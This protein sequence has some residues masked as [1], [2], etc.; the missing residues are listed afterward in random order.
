M[1]CKKIACLI[2]VLMMLLSFGIPASAQPTDQTQPTE[3]KLPA[4]QTQPAEQTKPT[5]QAQPALQTTAESAVLMEVATGKILFEKNPDKELPPASVTK[6]MTL[7]VALEAVEKGKVKLTD[8]VTASENASKMGGSQIYLEE[9][10]EFDLKTMLISVAV[11][12]ANDACVAV[13]EHIA[14]SH[15]AYVKMMN[16]KAAELGLKHTKFVN[17]YGLP[18]NGHY[19]SARDLALMM[20]EAIKYPLFNELTTI[21][22]HDL[23]GGKFVLLNTNKLLWWYKGAAG[24]K[25]GWTSEA[26][27]CLASTAN[28]DN[29]RLITVVMASPEPR[30]HFRESMKIFNYGFAQYEAVPIAKQG[31]ELGQVRVLKG[32][33]DDLRLAAKVDVGTVVKKGHKKDVTHKI[34]MLPAI[35]APVAE[36]QVIGDIK[37]YEGKEEVLKVDLVATKAIPKGMPFRQMVKLMRAVYN[38]Q[39]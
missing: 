5:E 14:G 31:Q 11:G 6:V 4:Q 9:G 17:A 3:Q 37:V 35:T 27:Y 10:E 19:T 12:S 2:V 26:K 7:L 30:S 23:R 32:T 24:G 18:A 13:A 38:Y 29:L 28:K 22:Q 21:K 25:T 15:E 33:V 39:Q 16:D 36:G 34:N 1:R 8:I 20:K